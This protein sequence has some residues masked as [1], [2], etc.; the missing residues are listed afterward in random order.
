M[1][2][3]C[4]CTHD[5]LF[6]FSWNVRP[7]R[8]QIGDSSTPR[9][10]SLVTPHRVTDSMYDPST[11][12]VV[13]H[14]HSSTTIL[15]INVTN[16]MITIRYLF[17]FTTIVFVVV[18]C[19]VSNESGQGGRGGHQ[20]VMSNCMCIVSAIENITAAKHSVLLT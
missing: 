5:L 12:V 20:I 10:F 6:K 1:Y 15:F 8:R 9:P 13:S 7:D 4:Y 18:V 3:I 17:V 19:S 2:A 16:M 14:L 11:T